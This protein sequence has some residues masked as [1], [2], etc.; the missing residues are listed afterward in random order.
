MTNKK[1]RSDLTDIKLS[2]MGFVHVFGNGP[3]RTL[4]LARV[5]FMH[6][7]FYTFYNFKLEN[8][9]TVVSNI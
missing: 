6:N 5:S 1:V 3:I 8:C 2:I 7:T 9:M 4:Y